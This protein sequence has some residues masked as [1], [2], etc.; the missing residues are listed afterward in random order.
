MALPDLSI[1]RP[2]ATAMAFLAIV[3]LGVIAFTRLPVDL[4]PDVA[5]PTLTIWTQ[6]PE[7]SASA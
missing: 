4:L 6:Y 3:L 1:R 7:A 2:V 5:F